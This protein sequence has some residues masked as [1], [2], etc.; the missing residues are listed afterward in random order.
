MAFSL[1]IALLAAVASSVPQSGNAS[2]AASAADA[3]LSGAPGVVRVSVGDDAPGSEAG[4]A[5]AAQH[6]HARRASAGVGGEHGVT[7]ASGA[8]GQPEALLAG[9]EGAVAEDA[10]GGQAEGALAPR[11]SLDEQLGV[12]VA[13]QMRSEGVSTPLCRLAASVARANAPFVRQLASKELRNKFVEQELAKRRAHKRARD[14]RRQLTEARERELAAT[15]N[16]ANIWGNRSKA[17]LQRRKS[18]MPPG[19]ASNGAAQTLDQ[20]ANEDP[21]AAAASAAVAAAEAAARSTASDDGSMPAALSLPAMTV[22]PSGLSG[23]SVGN[24]SLVPAWSLTAPTMAHEASEDEGGATGGGEG[25][26]AGAALVER[27]GGSGVLSGGAL[28]ALQPGSAGGGGDAT[29]RGGGVTFAADTGNPAAADAAPPAM[30][31]AHRRKSSAFLPPIGA[32]KLPPP[33][34]PRTRALRQ[35]KRILNSKEDRRPGTDETVA[36][37]RELTAAMGDAP[38][39][40]RLHMARARLAWRK[41]H[42]ADALMDAD[43]A[44]SLQPGRPEP[45]LFKHAI[46][47][48]RKAHGMAAKT[49]LD[50]LQHSPGDPM[51]ASKF[52]AE[53]LYLRSERTQ[54]IAPVRAEH[55]GYKRSAFETEEEEVV[56]D[57]V[58]RSEEWLASE[59]KD[60]NGMT[61]RLRDDMGDLIKKETAAD[62]HDLK[63]ALWEHHRAMT[64]I[65]RRYCVLHY[66]MDKNNPK[67]D[68]LDGVTMSNLEWWKL[69]S[70]I[71]V[72]GNKVT[73]ADVELIFIRANW[74]KDKKTKQFVAEEGNPD[75]AFLP[76]EFQHALLRIARLMYTA[77]RSANLAQRYRWLMA[78]KVVPNAEQCNLHPFRMRMNTPEFQ[79]TQTRYRAKLRAVFTWYSKLDRSD[80]LASHTINIEEWQLLLRDSDLYNASFT[81][82]DA[83]DCFNECQVDGHQD[84]LGKVNAMT[85]MVFN[86]F[87]EGLARAAARWCRE[88]DG[89]Q[90]RDANLHVQLEAFVQ[91]IVTD[92]WHRV[93]EAL[94]LENTAKE[95]KERAERQSLEKAGSLKRR[96]SGARLM[97]LAPPLSSKGV[98]NGVGS[99]M[100]ERKFSGRAD[101][102]RAEVPDLAR[103]KHSKTKGRESSSTE[104]HMARRSAAGNI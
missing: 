17:V 92:C 9:D 63:D 16:A 67:A 103:Q 1:R 98:G 22:A 34:S 73:K 52:R 83:F 79:R 49:L 31:L 39:S 33:R 41:N 10:E 46:L 57:F 50:G 71:K 47:R 12:E 101:Q 87:M 38:A 44:A 88:G 36:A 23:S 78:E 85:Q 66:N 58:D 100:L 29:D 96:P 13:V 61:A 102:Q 69:V 27:S 93:D 2:E 65:F 76:F 72:L 74:V 37:T 6:Q 51:M 80:H 43:T 42:L 55:R 21:A 104:M 30:A 28:P 15:Q 82:R 18:L 56:E 89:G 7:G 35:A 64:A 53:L 11:V 48:R 97:G 95:A 91:P 45:V 54:N 19:I 75:A 4:S 62:W 24:G 84:L 81:E 59:K 90:H 3:A 26:G 86:E 70:D 20:N 14:L 5:Q 94:Q 60:F 32:P 68:K 25:D 99:G 8:A 77:P 40:R